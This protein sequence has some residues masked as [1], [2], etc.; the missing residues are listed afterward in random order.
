[1]STREGFVWTPSAGLQAG[2]PTPSKIDPSTRKLPN[3]GDVADVIILGAGYAGLVAA[4]DL[5]TQGMYINVAMHRNHIDS[6]VL[7]PKCLAC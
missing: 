4:R 1:M 5:A 3:H 7:R 6:R 2:L